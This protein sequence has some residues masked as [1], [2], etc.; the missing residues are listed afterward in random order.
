MIIMK[1]KIIISF[2]LAFM[3]FTLLTGQ[4][5]RISYYMN[6]PQKRNLNPALTSSDSVY[7]GLPG[8]SGFGM[9]A[10]NNLFDFSDILQK[11][12]SDSLI[13]FL[14][15][16]ASIEDF[17]SRIREKNF[18]E[19]DITVPLFSLAF[20]V[21][22]GYLFFDINER[23]ESN[24][25]VPGSL[26]E[27]GL[28]GNAS[29][30]GDYLDFSALRAGMRI[31]HEF[32][33]GFSREYS[34]RLRVG[35]KGKVL[36]GLASLS[37]LPSSLGIKISENYT[38]TIDADLAINLSGP[39]NV[40]RNENNSI[41]KISFDENGFLNALRLRGP[42]N[43]GF[44]ADLGATYMM[45]KRIMVSAAVTDIGFIN[46]R[47][48]VTN[49]RTE[50]TFEFS[51]I[52]LTGVLNGD[53]DF[54]EVTSHL[55]DSLKEAF[56]FEQSNN[57]YS[58]MLPLGL[59]LGASYSISRNLTFGLLSNSRIIGKQIRESLTLSTNFRLGTSVSTSFSYTA[60]NHRYDNIGAGLMLRLAFMQFYVLSDNIPVVWN[61]FV[62]HDNRGNV[63]SAILLPDNL[64]T[65]DFRF[66]MN[67]VFGHRKARK[68]ANF[69]PAGQPVP[70]RNEL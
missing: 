3:Q 21:K 4:G 70:A 61:R 6:L 27:L 46:W 37:V 19:P 50:E 54:D 60:A 51:G 34:K 66:G 57:S 48:N 25:V 14:H 24:A 64:N 42:V 39:F 2:L 29:F 35:F 30:A 32:G 62:D 15:P 31:Y 23:I 20:P 33:L 11:G 28:R 52:D 67:L 18:I 55:T 44:A 68:A 1:N 69:V 56:T 63:E 8:F 16:D 53:E 13:T 26:I 17:I 47:N 9:N 65:I 10:N 41:E 7:I 58:T 45:T 59:N 36:F 40:V 12:N 5:S 49:L 43:P 38:H 22:K